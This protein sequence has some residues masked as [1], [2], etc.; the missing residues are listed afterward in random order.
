M[1]GIQK[2][3]Q[4]AMSL[5][6]WLSCQ[7]EKGRISFRVSAISQMSCSL[8]YPVCLPSPWIEYLSQFLFCFRMAPSFTVVTVMENQSSE[9]FVEGG[10]FF[11]KIEP[12]ALYSTVASYTQLRVFSCLAACE[13]VLPRIQEA[14]PRNPFGPR[15]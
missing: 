12:R 4:Y 14:C 8:I 10:H 6:A 3:S 7:Q 11:L 2:N 15:G 5:G 1:L 13:Q 9:A